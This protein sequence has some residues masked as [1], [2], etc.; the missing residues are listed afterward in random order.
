MPRTKYDLDIL[1]KCVKSGMSKAEIMTEMSIKNPPTFNSLMLKLMNTDNKFYK[2][3]ESGKK[4]A[5]KPPK[6][7]VG[8]RNTITLSSK[9]LEGSG[10]GPGDSFLVKTGKNRI[11]LI[12]EKK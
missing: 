6:V 11:T 7:I 3:R 10:F 9:I 1:R 5:G 8:K 2:V 4:K 12:L